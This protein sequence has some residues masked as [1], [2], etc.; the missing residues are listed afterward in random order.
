MTEKNESKLVFISHASADKDYMDAFMTHILK[1]GLGLSDQNIICTSFERTGVDAGDNI[2]QYIKTKIEKANIVLCMVSN[3]YKASEVC[4]NE[5][6]A[7]WALDKKLVSIVLPKISFSELG[8]LTNLDKAAKM[9]DE[10][11]L[12][13]LVEV[14]ANNLNLTIPT[15]LHWNPE[16][17][18]FL[19]AI[20]VINPINPSKE[21]NEKS[22]T[23]SFDN[24]VLP[25]INQIFDY[26]DIP[27]YQCWT[28]NWAI[29]GNSTISP[30]RLN[31]IFELQL[32]LNRKTTLTKFPEW[33][34]LLNNFSTLVTD[35][36]NL[37]RPYLDTSNNPFFIRKFYKDIPYNS[38][39]SEIIQKET[40]QYV[41]LVYL[42]HDITI[43]LTRFG[44]LI[45]SKTRE[46]IPNYR[47]TDGDLI[48]DIDKEFIKYSASEISNT[49]YPGLNRF[50]TERTSHKWALGKCTTLQDAGLAGLHI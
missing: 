20:S 19:N 49:P 50:L 27:N 35:F 10:E 47:I 16:K 2:P 39:N 12:D 5:V 43:E 40:E 25:I 9:D 26:L 37:S 31:E 44:N 33:D 7:A 15:P 24:I 1:S 21:E 41:E 18:K 29:A 30:K 23:T 46:I 42:I 6:G 4:M 8:W 34:D 48:M 36:I 14:I 38:T 3:N 32:F 11:S 28:Y 45:L 17:K 22:E 13:K